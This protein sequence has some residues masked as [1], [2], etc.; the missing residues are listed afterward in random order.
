MSALLAPAV[1]AEDASRIVR[2]NPAQIREIEHVRLSTAELLDEKFALFDNGML[3]LTQ[4]RRVLDEI[5]RARIF[6][7]VV[8]QSKDTIAVSPTSRITVFDG[9]KNLNLRESWSLPSQLYP[10]ERIPVELSGRD[11]DRYTEIKAD[12]LPSRRAF[13][14][15]TRPKLDITVENTDAKIGGGTLNFTQ[16]FTYKYVD[17][18]G[19]VRNDSDVAVEKVRV[20]ISLYDAKDQLTGTISQELR[21][22]RLAPGDTAPFE[23][24]VKQYGANFARVDVVYDVP[25]R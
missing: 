1:Q 17:I 14:P 15:G 3:A 12:W 20:W 2:V 24:S 16:R 13:L 9:G 22:P 6:A 5:G 25:A 11:F 21:L 18:R 8:N 7:V 10:G 23:A 19:R 4:P